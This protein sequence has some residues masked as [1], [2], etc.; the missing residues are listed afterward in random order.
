MNDAEPDAFP[1]ALLAVTV[2]E[3]LPVPFAR[4]E[5]LPLVPEP[6]PT[7]MPPQ[8]TLALV[9]PLVFQLKVVESPLV[10]AVVANEAL[11]TVGGGTM[12]VKLTPAL[13]LLPAPFETETVQRPVPEPE[14]VTV[15]E[16]LSAVL[17]P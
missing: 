11:V 1:P 9:A 4:T 15:I 3:P 16:P 12:T 6:E 5:M 7:A 14:V 8:E 10:N 2:H 13:S 17:E